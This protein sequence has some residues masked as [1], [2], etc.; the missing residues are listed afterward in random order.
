MHRRRG[1][2]RRA[3]A[4]LP[5]RRGPSCWAVGG[6]IIFAAD[7]REARHESTGAADHADAADP[8]DA[9]DPAAAIVAI[10]VPVPVDGEI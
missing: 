5:A 9:A 3:A 10:I 7:I 8:D 1:G 2:G 6:S 4:V